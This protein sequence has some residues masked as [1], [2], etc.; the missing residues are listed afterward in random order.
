MSAKWVTV[1]PGIRARDHTTRKHGVRLD[2]YSTV[3]FSVDG[4]QIEAARGWASAGWT[5]ARA[6]EELGKLREAKRTGQGPA[7]LRERAHAK[8]SAER[9]QAA[10]EAERARLEKTVADLWD[11][12][13]KEV[14]AVENK[15]RTAAEKTR[16]WERRI[17]RSEEH[18]SELQ[19]HHDLVCRL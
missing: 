18:T 3:R 13:S 4:R 17:K 14:V 6:Q 10:A 12:Y 2:R 8:R 16:L 7:T 5:L 9:Q 1:A 19:S 15:P 11:R